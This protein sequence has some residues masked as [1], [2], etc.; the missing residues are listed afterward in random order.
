MHYFVKSKHLFIGDLK[1]T[2]EGILEI[3]DGK[4]TE[5]SLIQEIKWLLQDLLMHMCIYIYPV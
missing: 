4:M 3:K 2:I 1:E 5:K